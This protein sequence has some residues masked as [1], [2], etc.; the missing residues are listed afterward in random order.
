MPVSE[1][2]PDLPLDLNVLLD[3]SL[4]AL[5]RRTMR[6]T[7]EPYLTARTAIEGKGS[8]LRASLDGT[9][10]FQLVENPDAAPKDWQTAETN[11]AP[12]RDIKVP[13]VWTL[14]NTGDHPHYTNWVMPFAEEK[15]PAVPE[16]NPT[17]LYRHAFSCPPDW[18]GRDVHIH[19]GGFESFLMVWCNGVF[20]GMGKDSR[21]PSAFNLGK[22]L[23][24]A[25]NQLALMVVRW[26]DGTWIE[27]QDH[28]YHGG[29]HRSVYLEAS[30]RTHIADLHIDADYDPETGAGH[31]GLT[32]YVDGPSEG[33]K[34]RAQILDKDGK[35][36]GTFPDAAVSQ[37][38]ATADGITQ[39]IQS[40][41]MFGYAARAELNLPNIAP[42][43]AE[44]PTR[45]QLVTELLDTDNQI[46]E[47]SRIWIGFRRIETKDRR[48]KINGRDI[49]IIGVNR[50]DH[51]P[52][53]GKTLTRD[54][55]RAELTQM[56]RAN[57]NAVRTAHYP[58]DPVLLDLCDELGLYVIDEA[59]VE[60]HGRY[61]LV[62]RD[63]SYQQAIIGRT[64]RTV[65][66][67][68]NH[69]SIIG[70]STGNEAGHGPAH[71]AAAAMAR[72]L[73]PTRFVQ[74]EG[75]MHKM[76]L[77]FQWNRETGL[78]A[79]SDSELAASDIVCPMY[80]PIDYI[81]DWA[82]WAEATK[83]DD[84]PMILCEYSHAM[85]N[86]N[87][88][89]TEYVE[90]FFA[91]GPLAGGF[92]WDWRDQGLSA[93]DEHDR[94]YWAYGG[95]YDDTPND[96]NFNING[97]VGPDLTP[98]PQLREY[99]WA[100]R[101]VTAT[102]SDKG[103]ITL[104]NRR[105]VADTSDLSLHWTLQQ[106]GA[107]I[108]TGTLSPKIKAG[109]TKTIPLPTN[110]RGE[111]LLI[112]WK[113]AEGTAWCE[114]GYTI[115]WDQIVLEEPATRA[116][117]DFPPIPRS[118]FTEPALSCGPAEIRFAPDGRI[119]VI[120]LN[121]AP[122]ILSDPQACLWR[123]PTD[124][125]GGK[126]LEDAAA[127]PFR[128]SNT[129]RWVGYG[130]NTLEHGPVKRT[131]ERD[132]NRVRLYLHRT[133]QGSGNETLIHETLWTLTENGADITE[134]LQI[135]DNWQDLPRIGI[136]FEA[137]SALDHLA[138]RGLGPDESYPDRKSAQTHGHWYRTIA[139]QYHPF[140]RP[141]EHGNH[142]QTQCFN[143]R[144]ATGEGVEFSFPHPLA[145]TARAHHD[146]ALNEA[147]TLAELA[148]SPTTEIHIDVATRGLGTGACGPDVLDP[149][150]VH[151][152]TYVFAW[153]LGLPDD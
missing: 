4:L 14:Q 151:G 60:C 112:E 35:L 137:P 58:N 75:A 41:S 31:A 150:K 122:V 51:H 84:R 96:A 53:T 141:Q 48:L 9:W 86:S 55:I 32:V 91:H 120:K 49:K 127:Q 69:P 33:Y 139:D 98:H 77:L 36:I 142:E 130:L 111:S 50:H 93:K 83:R 42:W 117:P 103:E 115:A 24:A 18:Q 22:A 146:H 25:E 45:F 106:N 126:P 132:G 16:D 107:P 78:A 129:M 57:I 79:P 121:G 40:V 44:V 29:L 124:N 66:R 92:I 128:L 19:I 95:H 108:E 2:E 38:D 52:D 26:S 74:Y 39:L 109:A 153:S 102:R 56:K 143:L 54:E 72:H 140:V 99:Q 149:Y 27:D 73:D 63:P 85:G 23:N 62:S 125:D 104:H 80:P 134:R 123:A 94:F 12:W 148:P 28:W 47:A 71:N 30:A 133:W 37:F 114:K 88:S 118:E 64:V 136:R 11:Q 67:D 97:L 10:R 13:G 147:Q 113:L 135:P 43:S 101:P 46:I 65:M 119:D 116:R 110:T 34:T 89:L 105:S 131:M 152:G 90:A 87:G 17:G 3:P 5:N 144:S 6:T 138:W 81:I 59:N 8:S 70:W 20:I 68:R 145:F 15:P 1:R 100:A 76:G 61:Q 21:L 7:R 82:N